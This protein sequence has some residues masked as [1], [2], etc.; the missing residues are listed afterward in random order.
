M[1]KVDVAPLAPKLRNNRTVHSDYLKHT[2]E[3]TATLREIVKHERSLNL[4]NTSLDY[5]F[6]Q[7][8]LWYLDSG[9][10]KHMIGDHSQLINFVDK[11]LG[12]VKFVNDHMAKIMG[13]GD[14]QIENVTISRVYFV[15][16]LGHKL[17]SVRQFCESD[18]EVA[19]CQHT[20]F[21]RN[22]EGVNLLFNSRGNNL[23]TLSLGDMMK[24][25]PIFLLSKA[26]KTKSWL[27]HQ[28]LSHLN[29]SAINHL[30][31]Q[32][33]VGVGISHETYVSR[34]PQQND[35]VERRNR[36]LIEAA[37]T[38]ENLGKLQ[39][40]ADIGIFIGY[41]PIKKAFRIYNRRTRQIIETIHVV[42]DELTAMASEQ[43][44]SGLTLH[45]MTHAIISLGLVPNPT[46]L[47]PFVPPLDHPAPEVISLIAEVVAPKLAASTS[48]PSSTTVDQDAPSPSILK[49]KAQ[50][51]ACGY[52]QEDGIAF[53]ESFAS[54]ARLEAIRIFLAYAAHINMVVYQMDV[55]TAFLNGK[56]REEV[57]VS[58]PDGFVDPDNPNYMYKLK[59]ALYGLKQAPRA[60]YDMLSSFLISQDFSKGSVD[61]TLFIHG[62]SNAYFCPR[63][64]F[65]NQSKYALKSLKK[66]GFEYCDPVDTPMVE[67][68]KLDEDKE[69]K[70]AD[71][72]HYCGKKSA[73]ISSTEA[74]YIT[75]S[76]CCAQILWMRSQLTDYGLGFKK[77][78]MYYDNKSAIALCCNNV[79]HFMS[80]H[81]NIR[82][83][84]I[85]EHVKNGVIELY[86][87]NTEYQLVDIFTKALGR[88]RIEFLINKL[89]MRS[90]TPETPQ[91]LIDE[92]DETMDITIDQKVALDEALVPHANR[93]RI[94]KTDVPKIYM[95]E[96][97]ATATVHHHSICFK[98][99]NKKRIVN[100]EYFREMLQIYP[101]IPNQQFDELPFK[102]EILAFLRQL[103]HSGEIKMKPDVNIKKLY[104]PWRSFAVVTNKCLSGKS[105][106]SYKEYY[107]I[108]SEAEPPKT[109]ASVKKKQSS[110]DTTMPPPTTTGKRLK[111]S[112]KVGKPAKEKQPAKPSK[113]KGLTVLSEKSSKDDDDDDDDDDEEKIS[114][115]DDDVDDQSD[116]ND[117]DDQDDDDDDEQT[118]SD[119]N[120]D[121]FVH[122]KF[123][124][125]DEEDKDEE[126]FDSIVQTPSQVK[127]T[128][129]EDNDEYIH[130][131]NVEGDEM[132]DEGANEEDEANELCRDVNINLEGQDV[133]MADVQTTQVIKDT[134][135]TLT[136]VNPEGQQQSLSV[137]S[138]FVSNMLNPSP[139][140]GIDS[141]FDS[142]PRVNVPVTTTAEPPLLST[143][144][145]PPPSIPI[146]SHVQRTPAPSPANV[147]SSSLL[148]D[149][150]EAENEDFLNK[151]DENIQKIIKEQVK[152]Q[153][154]TSHAVAADLSELEPKK[155][156]IDKMESNKSTHRSDEQRILQSFEPFGRTLNKKNLFLYTRDYFFDLMESLSLYMVA[157][158]KLPILN[159]TEFDLWKMRIEQY[160]LMTDYSLW[161]AKGTL[162]IALLDKHQLKFNIYKDAKSLMEDIE[163]R[164]QKLISQLEILGESL[165][166]R[167]QF[168]ILEKLTIRVENSHSDLEEQC[169]FGRPNTNESV[170]AVTSVSAAST[171]VPVFSLPNV[172]NL[173]DAVI[174]SFFASQSNSPHLDNDDLKQIDADDLEEMDLK[175]QMAK[176]TMRARRFLQRTGRN[177][178]ANGTTSIGFDMSKVEC[179][180]CHIRGHFARECSNDWRFQADEEPTNYALMTFTFS[181]SSS[182]DNEVA[183]CLESVKARLVVYQQNENVFEEDIKLLKLDVML[184]DNALVELK[185][186]FEADENKRDD[187]VFD[188]DE[189]ISSESDVS[190]PTSPVHDRPSVKPVEHSTSTINFRKDIPKSRGH[191]HCRNRKTCFVCKRLTHL[192]KDCDYYEKKMVQK[193][194][195][196]NAIRGNHQH[197]ARMTHSHPHRHVVPTAVFTRSRLVPFAAARPVTTDVSQTKVQ[198]QRPS[199]PGFNKAHLPIRRPINLRPSPT[200]SNFHQKITTVKANQDK[201]VIDSG[202]SRHMTGNISYLFEFEEI[203]EGYV[204]FGGNPKGGKIT[205]KENIKFP[206]SG[207]GFCPRAI[208]RTLLK[209]TSF[210][211]S[212]LTFS[213]FMDPLTPQVISVAKLPILNPNDFDLWKMRIEQYFLM[214]DYSLWEVILNGDSPVPTR[215]VEGVSQP[216]APTT[217]EQ[218]LARNNELKAR[219]TLF[220]ALPDKQQLKFNSH[221][222]AKTLMEAIEKRFA[223]LSAAASVSAACVKLFASPLLND[224][225]QIDVDDLEEMDLR[226]KGHFA[227][228]CRSLK[229]QRRPG[230]AEPQRRTVLV[231]TS[232]SNALVSQCDGTGR[233]DWSYQADEEPANF[234][235]MDFSLSSSFDNEC[236]KQTVVATSSTEAEYVAAASCCAQFWNTVTIKQS[237]DVT[238]LQALVDK[239]KV[240]ILEASLSAKRMSWNEFSF[241]MASAVICLSIGDLSTHSTKYI[242]PTLTQKVFANMRRV[243]KGCL[244]VETP[245]FEGAD[246]DVS[247]DDVQ[248]QLIPSPAPPTPP[249][250]P[251]AIPSTSYEALDA[252]VILTR[253]V[254]H[255]E[256]D[257]VAQDLEI[258]KLKTRVKKLERAN[259][260]RM[261]DKLDRDEGVAL[262]GEKEEERKAEEVKVTAGDA[263]VKGSQ[264]EIYQ[265]NIDHVVKVLSMQ[266]E[267]PEVQEVVEVV[268]TAKLITEVVTAASTPVSAASTTIP[269]AEPKVPTAAPVKVAAASTRRRRGVIIRDPEEESTAIT[270][271]DTKSKDKGKGIMVEEPK[272]M[273][274][275]QHVKID[276][277]YARKLHQELNQDID[278][279]V[280]I[281][282][283]KQNAK[284][285]P[286]V[287][288]YQVMKKRRQTEAQ[289]RGNMITYLKNTAGF[290]LDYFKGMS[291]DDIHPIFKVKFNANMEFLLKSKE[292]IEEEENRALESINETPPQKAAKQR[293]EDLESLWSLVQ[294]RFST[295]KPNNFSD[296]YLLTTLRAMFGKPD[297][298]DN[299]WKSQRTDSASRKEIPTFE[300]YIGSNAKRSETSSRRAKDKER[301]SVARTPQQNG[302]VERKKRTLIEA[303][304]TMLADS[305]LP[306]PFWAK[307]VNTACYVQ[308]RVLVTKPHNKTSYELLLS[309]TPSIGFM[310]PFGC[311]VAILN[312]LDLIEKFDGKADELFLVGYSVRS[313]STWL[314]DIDTL[315]QSMNYHL[316]IPGNQP[317]SSAGIQE[318]L[319]AGTVRKEAKSVQQYV[320]LPLWSSSSKDP[321]NTDDAAFEVKEPESTVYVSP[322][323]CDKTKKHDNMTKREAKGNI[324]AVGPNS[325]NSTNT[326]SA[327]GPSNYAVSLNFE[328]GGKSSLVDPSQYP[329]DPDMPALEDITYS[330]DE[331]D[332]GAEADF[333][334]LET[335]ITVSPIPITRVQKII[336]LLKSLVIYLQLLKQGGHTQEEGIDYEEVFAPL[337]RI[338]AIR[339]FLAYA[340][341]MGFM[342]YQMNVKSAFLYGTIEEEVYVYQPPGFEDPANPDK[343][344]KVVKA[345]YGLHQAPRAWYDTL[346]NYPLENGFQRGKIDQTLFIKKKKGDILMVQM[347]SMGELTFFLGLQVNQKQD[348]IFISQD[349]YVVDILRKFGLTDGKLASTLI[350]TKKP[351]LKDPDGEDMDTVVATSSTETEYVA[352]AS[353]CAHV[354]WIPN[355]LLDYGLVRNVDSPSKFFMYPRFLQL[356]INAQIADLSSHNTKYTSLALT[357]KVFANMRRIRK[358][359]SRVDTPLFDC[360][361]VPQQ[362]QDVEDAVEDEDDVNEVSTE[363]T[364]PSPT[365]A[366]PPLPP[367]QEHIPSP[368]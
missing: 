257:K 306:I 84:F 271:T 220:M 48:S 273:K 342:V 19:F 240:L 160:F 99:N 76:G 14:Y 103:G 188:Y 162:L 13:Y 171:N 364:P 158:A 327:V 368:P 155:I 156:L 53:E 291:Y 126:S 59:K 78:P 329:N 64:I 181:S 107:A 182:F 217:A 183:P 33:L 210:L 16:G 324:T 280:A 276:R 221:K 222:D 229:D 322:S 237:A 338:K 80:K 295:S 149:E 244:G 213:V 117:Q 125:H 348:G 157:A 319:N 312:T 120:V 44:S 52:R 133:Q 360:M 335:N 205:G 65:I 82:Y 164:L 15:D 165:S 230:T 345:L 34:S 43:S 21:I 20:C 298:Q 134:H 40:K 337:S 37:R 193:P 357:Q 250:S 142:T 358:G 231:E 265:I 247:G 301:D 122:P 18:L 96:F 168:E 191:R 282:H 138:R 129:D 267:E 58:Q 102:E 153:V 294:E 333:S 285:D 223:L 9:C 30:A 62:N 186:K 57:Y 308:N 309:R 95:Q 189:L 144:T 361:L 32:G 41:A 28:R 190:M 367:H 61:P 235:L 167:Y 132:D 359:F 355:Q 8:V 143:T 93:L 354:L 74:E 242:Y 303:A 216:V 279:D 112:A 330:D 141:I 218:R 278:W 268:T 238:R 349:K 310:K 339:L 27:W 100:L 192:I 70:A 116:D 344:Y 124:T 177:L 199:K 253:R 352:A 179:Y 200:H 275:K 366:T 187:T 255:L 68:S 245:L 302:I 209:R 173:S 139:D 300:V 115:H 264:G 55:K 224:L 350:D 108:A 85:K 334:N 270:P 290:R 249:P 196:N 212:T 7:I 4:L 202:C 137:S 22:L 159:P 169:R 2:Q 289:A 274:K 176:L 77:I 47:M 172:D 239:K 293:R 45:E 83:H 288:R 104:Q 39:P 79:Q 109:K 307:A 246:A 92:V 287:Q 331:E 161:E 35:V 185:K 130:G 251:Q 17:F 320:L 248:D 321:Q 259:K 198:H 215:I 296:D 207:F 147:P 87:V 341:F 119:N 38:I 81:I 5:A 154:K 135:V 63:G 206:L 315:T 145:L 228:E 313:G 336:L 110:F 263:Y 266:E 136:L 260:G 363:P 105:T 131:M 128:D 25:C 1:L 178:G 236:K 88:E 106:E 332:V 3:E 29:F 326:F 127:N 24:S 12:M 150:A 49:N 180:N 23:Y 6:V 305:L 314:F 353:C 50:L 123:S 281:E 75:L 56:L 299:V 89:G 118:N 269:V 204:A 211:H 51:V 292:Q 91:Q 152:E 340:S 86:F 318:N 194:V 286:F 170:S 323:S 208:W 67:K 304:R 214:I 11:F 195:R 362:A 113:A 252:C 94:G 98:M 46:S 356:T 114:E 10:S 163:N 254:E 317:T 174:Y 42:F 226:W 203:N 351:L 97:W 241:T 225:K 72:S 297:G 346:A 311:H 197:Y 328:L 233:Y 111:T 261:I 365:P 234:A 148:Q 90:F 316:V 121:D 283:V 325:T 175:W 277:A 73:A 232:T 166:R 36:T 54:V 284:E 71:P 66:Y 256:H 146:I 60:L 31:R 101:R 26:S 201:G 227:R 258:T 151:L 219:G 272:P 69:G 140:T 343:V 262:M 184:R 243:G 347:S